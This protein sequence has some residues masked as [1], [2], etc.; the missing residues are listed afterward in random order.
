MQERECGDVAAFNMTEIYLLDAGLLYE[1]EQTV[2][3]I[4]A[5]LVG[6]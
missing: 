1:R 2:H 3:A 6:G 4:E 5:I